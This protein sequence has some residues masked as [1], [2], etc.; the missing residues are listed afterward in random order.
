[1][2][3]LETVETSI[4]M[5]RNL[6]MSGKIGKTIVYC[7]LKCAFYYMT[8][9]KERELAEIDIKRLEGLDK[10]FNTLN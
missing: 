4:K 1:M 8:S 9:E 10:A 3:E 6:P 5:L 7:L 2:S